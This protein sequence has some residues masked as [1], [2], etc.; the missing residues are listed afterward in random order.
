M[1][2]TKEIRFSLSPRAA[3]Q[4]SIAVR[5]A[6]RRVVICQIRKRPLHSV[7]RDCVSPLSCHRPLLWHSLVQVQKVRSRVLQSSQRDRNPTRVCTVLE[8][9]TR[10]VLLWQRRRGIATL[11]RTSRCLVRPAVV[12]VAR[13]GVFD[14]IFHLFIFRANARPE[15]VNSTRCER[16]ESDQSSGLS[17]C[18]ERVW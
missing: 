9:R 10:R 2:K 7:V 18:G 12:G 6:C 8:L 1:W 5:I 15:W 4:S 16:E 17:E 13:Q 3:P 14:D 11:K